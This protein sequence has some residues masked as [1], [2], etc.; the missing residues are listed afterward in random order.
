VWILAAII[1]VG[2]LILVHEFGHFLMAKMVGVGVEVFCLGFGPMLLKKRIGQTLYG[3]A[4]VPLGGFVKLTGEG[5]QEEVPEGM[6]ESSFTHR[7]VFARLLI[8]LGGPVFNVLFALLVFIG[9]GL[10]GSERPAPV[11]GEVLEGSPALAYGLRPQDRIIQ[12]DGQKIRT[13]DE[14]L[15]LVQQSQGKPLTFRIQRETQEIQIRII[16]K[17]TFREDIF[18]ENKPSWMIGLA[19]DTNSTVFIRQGPLEAIKSGASNT[20]KLIRLTL[21]ALYKML[22]GTLSYKNI[23]GP[24]QI[25]A[26]AGEQARSGVVSALFFLSVISVNLGIINLLPVPVLDGGHVLFLTIEAITGRMPSMKTRE[27]AQNIG[28]FLLLALMLLAFYNDIT[29]LLKGGLLG[30]G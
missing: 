2:V 11:I 21:V 1:M 17:K 30:N 23:A 13:W 15:K 27:I 12:I 6:L 9:L 16:P 7:S 19:P 8:I 5:A 25:F 24:V 26:L 10:V 4:L 14:L 22:T 20:F 29:R 28:L 3:V 18:G